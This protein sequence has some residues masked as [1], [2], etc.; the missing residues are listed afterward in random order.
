MLSGLFK[1]KQEEQ[2]GWRQR[3]NP[4]RVGVVIVLGLLSIYIA[5]LWHWV[6]LQAAELSRLQ[7]ENAKLQAQVQDA[8]KRLSAIERR[9]PV[10]RFELGLSH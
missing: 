10:G 7:S 3:I 5:V 8:Q 4:L 1:T 6:D 9:L 2:A